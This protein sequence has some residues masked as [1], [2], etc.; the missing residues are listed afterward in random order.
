MFVPEGHVVQ[1]EAACDSRLGGPGNFTTSTCKEE[2]T[3][4][5]IRE[6]VV[7]V[8]ARVGFVAMGKEGQEEFGS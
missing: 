8:S 4:E 7:E 6:V 1:F 5:D 2:G 3:K